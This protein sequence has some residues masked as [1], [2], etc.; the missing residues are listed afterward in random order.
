[1]QY[2]CENCEFAPD[3]DYIDG[4]M[5]EWPRCP[6]CGENLTLEAVHDLA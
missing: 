2:R 4:W 5:P 3:R 1:M 6:V